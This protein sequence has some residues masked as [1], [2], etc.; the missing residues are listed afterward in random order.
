[1]V[2]YLFSPFIKPVGAEVIL[3]PYFLVGDAFPRTSNHP[4]LPNQW[5][6]GCSVCSPGKPTTIFEVFVLP[7]VVLTVQHIYGFSF[8]SQLIVERLLVIRF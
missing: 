2:F 4:V 7:G 1:M 5:F 3:G 8:H 6:T